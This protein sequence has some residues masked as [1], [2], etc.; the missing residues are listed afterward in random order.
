MGTLVLELYWRH[1][2]RTCKNFAEL[3]RRGYYNGT[4]FHRVIRDFMV[5]GGDP[6]GTGERRRD[7]GTPRREQRD[8]PSRGMGTVGAP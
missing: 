4:R 5:Q 8:P 2:P 3:C 1:A 6:T 7:T